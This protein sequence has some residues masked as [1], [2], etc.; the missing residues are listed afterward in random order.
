[1]PRQT[2]IQYKRALQN[3]Y[4]DLRDELHIKLSEGLIDV[5]D[6]LITK[7]RS[8]IRIAKMNGINVKEREVS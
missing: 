7:M 6:P 4:R 3:R 1:M 5:D 2:K 8:I